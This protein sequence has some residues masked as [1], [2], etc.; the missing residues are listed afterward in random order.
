MAP[1]T[2]TARLKQ[3]AQM[4]ALPTEKE[5]MRLLGMAGLQDDQMESESAV[6][7]LMIWGARERAD[8]ETADLLLRMAAN[9][10]PMATAKDALGKEVDAKVLAELGPM[11]AADELLA[12]ASDRLFG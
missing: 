12:I 6:L 3:A 5:A 4:E 1:T 8:H 7:S 11:A 2:E 9:K 10:G